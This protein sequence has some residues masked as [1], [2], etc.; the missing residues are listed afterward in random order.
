M[1]A[2]AT[3][4]KYCN[5]TLKGP[6]SLLEC[7]AILSNTAL[8]VYNSEGRFID[9]HKLMMVIL[10]IDNLIDTVTDMATVLEEE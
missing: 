2:K 10:T 5:H 1:G 4:C 9:H 6:H 3:H 7:R 8:L